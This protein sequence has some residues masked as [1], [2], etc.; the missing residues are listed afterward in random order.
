MSYAWEYA[1][2]GGALLVSLL[3]TG[4]VRRYAIRQRILDVP[5]AR[6]SHV[7]AT[8]RGGGIAIAMAM[9][10]ALPLLGIL[11][12]LRWPQVWGIAGGGALVAVAGYMDDDFNLA[13]QWRLLGHHLHHRAQ[14]ALIRRAGIW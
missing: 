14:V 4:Q 6:S 10:L 1:L 3:V 9:L 5:N 7:L 2:V 12:A 8:P 11:G 13:A